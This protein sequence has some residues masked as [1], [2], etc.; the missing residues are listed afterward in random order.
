MKTDY[1]MDSIEHHLNDAFGVHG[2]IAP[3][4]TASSAIDRTLET[5]I[6]TTLSPLLRTSEEVI[7]YGGECRI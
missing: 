3:T 6:D 2:E 1:T 7:H 4:P 5:S